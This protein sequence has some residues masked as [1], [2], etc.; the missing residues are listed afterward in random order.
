MPLRTLSPTQ[1]LHSYS[2]ATAPDRPHQWVNRFPITQAASSLASR[3]RTTY[4]SIRPPLPPH[5]STSHFTNT[6]SPSPYN[7]QNFSWVGID[8]P[9]LGFGLRSEQTISF[10]AA[11]GVGEGSSTAEAGGGID[12]EG[13]FLVR[14]G[15]VGGLFP[16]VGVERD[17]KYQRR[18]LWSGLTNDSLQIRQVGGW[19]C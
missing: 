8:S 16:V 12:Y 11:R 17:V 19:L 15:W 2:P 14:R 18:G 5:Y 10:C 3:G 6:A 9:S 7:S 4:I 13:D 1:R